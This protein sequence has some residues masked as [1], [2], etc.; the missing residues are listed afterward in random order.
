M[1]STFYTGGR[2]TM[3]NLSLARII[4]VGRMHKLPIGLTLLGLMGLGLTTTALLVAQEPAKQA[5]AGAGASDAGANPD[6]GVFVI[7]GIGIKA[8]QAPVTVLDYQGRV[9]NGLNALDFQ[10]F[11]NGKPQKIVEDLSEVR[12]TLVD[13]I[14]ANTGMEKILPQIRKIGSLFDGLVLGDEGEIAVI[15]F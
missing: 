7:P 2:N 1:Q 13:T 4:L 5:P 10:L 9:V 8:V 11:D 14:Q 6:Q 15:A 3:R 12:I